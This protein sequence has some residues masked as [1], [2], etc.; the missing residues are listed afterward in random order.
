MRDRARRPVGD[1]AGKINMG[2]G[3]I[4]ACVIGRKWPPAAARSVAQG[5]R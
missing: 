4:N 3:G 5:G 1:L 2:V